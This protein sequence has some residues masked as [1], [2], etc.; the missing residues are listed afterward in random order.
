MGLISC[1]DCNGKVSEIAAACP[2]CGRPNTVASAPLR[3]PPPPDPGIP[4]RR[5]EATGKVYLINAAGT[6]V[7][8]PGH[9]DE[10]Y[11]YTPSDEEKPSPAVKSNA[12]VEAVKTGA[13]G[14]LKLLTVGGKWGVLG[15]IVLCG[16]VFNE[17]GGQKETQLVAKQCSVC[18]TT[19][20][21]NPKNK[22]RGGMVAI[23]AYL[24]G[25]SFC[26][27]CGKNW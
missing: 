24:V 17:C 26:P 27:K 19:L 21:Y 23:R 10:K 15:I 9:P 2:H 16:I 25:P 8:V 18:D 4:H 6:D 20:T 13:M 7:H 12:P 14:L 5:D 22:N 3:P 11:P 1:P